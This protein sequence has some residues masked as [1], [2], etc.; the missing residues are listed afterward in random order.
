MNTYPI[1]RLVI[2]SPCYNEEAILAY[3]ANELTLL[4]ERLI[5]ANKILPK[6]H[7][8]YVNDG[9]RDRTWEM[10]EALHQENPFIDGLCLAGN[11][12]H[13]SAIMAGM[14][15]AKEEADVVI[16]RATIS[17]M[18]SRSHVGRI[19]SLSAPRLWP[20]IAYRSPWGYGLFIIMQTLDS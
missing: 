4:L 14:M 13:Q 6:S 3:S 18:V 19:P 15:V 2:V 1:P 17:S 12:G 11:V 10:I 5:A 16:W 7:I 9:S 8:L 20:S